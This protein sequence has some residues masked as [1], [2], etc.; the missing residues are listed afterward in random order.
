[1]RDVI[2]N[3]AAGSGGQQGEYIPTVKE[4][5]NANLVSAVLRLTED[6]WN[7]AYYFIAA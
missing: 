7:E 3:R 1:M 6:V 5:E 2:Y 4:E